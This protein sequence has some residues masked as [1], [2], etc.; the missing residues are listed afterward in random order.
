MLKERVVDVLKHPETGRYWS[1]TSVANAIDV[2]PSLLNRRWKNDE[3]GIGYAT[4]AALTVG[5]GPTST[6]YADASTSSPTTC[7]KWRSPTPVAGSRSSAEF[8]RSPKL[9]LLL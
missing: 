4:A 7:A 1:W 2:H 8:F 5:D 3:G 9:A 6:S